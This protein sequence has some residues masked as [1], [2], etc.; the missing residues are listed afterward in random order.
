MTSS[1]VPAGAGASYVGGPETGRPILLLHGAGLSWRMWLPQVRDLEADYRVVAPDL[2]AHGR[3]ASDSFSLEDG[4][5]VAAESLADAGVTE[6]AL[7][8]G[9]SLGGYVGIELAARYPDRVAGL[10]PSGASANYRGWL[11]A[12]T[13]LA[14]LVA[15]LGAAV[16][17]LERRFRQ[18]VRSGLRSK[19]IQNVVVDAILDGGVSAA[20]YGQGAMAIAGIDSHATLRA[21]DGPVLLLNGADDRLNP[22]A[23]D[24]L[25]P[26]LP[27]AR[28][29]RIADAGHTCNLDRPDAYTTA[30]RE[31]ATDVVWP[32]AAGAE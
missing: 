30:I 1:D 19:P 24:R 23:A 13:A 9:Q 25:A 32:T 4:V 16:A 22:P 29:R 3:R 2:P 26:T 27:D 8:V 10:V 15:R 12:K 5:A 20:G 17:P 28:T 11:A 21:Y 7:V 14:G 18:H 31:F 6:S